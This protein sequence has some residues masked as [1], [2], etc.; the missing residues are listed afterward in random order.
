MSIFILDPALVFPVPEDGSE[1]LDLMV[2]GPEMPGHIKPIWPGFYIRLMPDTEEWQWNE[3][4]DG[5]WAASGIFM[6]EIQETVWR[7]A[8]LKATDQMMQEITQLRGKQ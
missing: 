6:H 2:A 1:E 5:Y 3:F 4:I 8:I 7:G